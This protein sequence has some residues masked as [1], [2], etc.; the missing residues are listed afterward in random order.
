MRAQVAEGLAELRPSQPVRSSGLPRACARSFSHPA[1]KTSARIGLSL[2]ESTKFHSSGGERVTEVSCGGAP[3]RSVMREWLGASGWAL[4]ARG[5]GPQD[6]RWEVRQIQ[7]ISIQ[8]KEHNGL[9]LFHLLLLPL[10]DGPLLLVRT[11]LSPAWGRLPSREPSAGAAG[12]PHQQAS[13]TLPR[14]RKPSFHAACTA[15]D[16]VGRARRGPSASRQ[17]LASRNPHPPLQPRC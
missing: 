13:V 12:H 7:W 4:A 17:F 6:A 16:R 1:D 10:S 3:W 8:C 15:R 14:P 5:C 9:T 11:P 2:P